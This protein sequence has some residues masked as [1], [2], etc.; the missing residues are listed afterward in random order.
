VI[1]G[2]PLRRACDYDS[3]F[4]GSV[5]EH[6]AKNGTGAFPHGFVWGAATAAYQ[7]EGAAREDGRGESIWDRF[8]STAGKVRNGDSGEVACDFYHRYREDVALLDDLGI[9][10]FRFSIAWPRVLPDGRGKVNA[11]GLDFYDRLVDELLAIGIRPFPTLYHWDLPQA[12]EDAGGWPSRATVEA[13]CEYAE[14]VAA[15]LGDRVT[16]WTTHNEP[17]VAAWAGYGRG[18]HAPGRTD[19]ADALAA[20]HHL[21]LSHGR[22]AEVLRREVPGA[23]VGITLDL[24]PMEP[25]SDSPED[26]AAAYEADGDQNR[27][28]LDPLFRGDYPEDMVELFA[29]HAPHVEDGDLATIAAPLDFLGINYYRREVYE[30]T[31]D[32]GRRVLHQPGSLYTEM[33]WEVSPHG[34]HKLLVRLRDDYAPPAIYITE[35]GAAFG[36]VRGHD[37]NVYDPERRAYIAEHIREIGRAAADG[38]PV[39]GYFVW[40]LMDNFEWAHGYCKRFGLV[41]VDFPTLERV[42]KSSFYWYR[43]FIAEVNGKH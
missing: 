6:V 40:S 16:D 25:A 7:I 3:H 1:S 2:P 18:V 29:P 5:S 39:A 38:V 33:G 4:T 23:R 42:P 13:F 20:A 9:G 37:G 15:R 30:R 35:N 43:D 22:A 21:L 28:F 8:C 17:H 14:V 36:D 12:L 19:T 31:D 32:G 34:L 11:A 26:L 27:W 24:W 41:Y 10:G